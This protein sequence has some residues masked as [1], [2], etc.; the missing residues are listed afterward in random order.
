MPK[1]IYDNQSFLQAIEACK[2]RVTVGYARVS[3][4][5]K[6]QQTSID[7]QVSVLSAAGC[8]IILVEKE[9]GR[10]PQRIL[11][12]A[13]VTHID[14]IKKISATRGD[15]IARDF[16]EMR[17]FYHLCED[18]NVEWIFIDEPEL[19]FDSMLGEQQRSQKAY[20][21]ELEAINISNRVKKAYISAETNLKAPNRRPP[22]GYRIV[23]GSF[24]LDR[25][26][27]DL[28]NCVGY[29]EGKPVATYELAR[30]LVDLF[31]R[32]ESQFKAIK[33]YQE[34]IISKLDPILN[35]TIVDKQLDRKRSGLRRWLLNP[36]LL[37]CLV[38][39]KK[40][41]KR[42][43]DRLEKVRWVDSPRAEWRIYENCHEPLLTQSELKQTEIIISRNE[44]FGYALHSARQRNDTV[45][46]LSPILKCLKCGSG[47]TSNR[48]TSTHKGKK[49]QYRIYYCSKRKQQRCTQQGISEKRIRKALVE[50]IISKAENLAN[51]LINSEA[52]IVT[53]DEQ[54]LKLLKEEAEQSYRKYLQ[55]GL[56]VY[57][58]AHRELKQQS[59]KLE[60]AMVR[61]ESDESDR[62]D[63]IESL[64]NPQFWSEMSDLDLHRYLR[65]VVAACWMDDKEIARLDL[66]L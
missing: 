8:E 52:G 27:S 51:I 37:G 55:T 48:Q 46:P 11:Y 4:D 42:Y 30:I 35:Q 34:E 3:T 59:S 60:S 53:P 5:E 29:H 26:K 7:R 65:G 28:S 57:L 14:K 10:K 44:N 1:I 13:I 43:G 20:Y 64:S 33:I 32:E 56:N 62:L 12:R 49:Y 63:L 23:D 54:Q 45:K 2:D 15:R 40:R 41:P 22:F 58:E 36:I 39:G 16:S 25:L 66:N 61:V 24:E 18:K 31:I 9:S 21:A 38:Y 47:Y 19:N 17:F 6:E 50:Q